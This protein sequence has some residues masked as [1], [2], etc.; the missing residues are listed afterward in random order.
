[1]NPRYATAT[2]TTVIV[3]T[4]AIAIAVVAATAA[5]TATTIPTTAF[6]NLCSS[7]RHQLS[8]ASGLR[9]QHA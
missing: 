8:R 5:I 6:L 7:E 4:V 9:V 2:T 3:A 1:M